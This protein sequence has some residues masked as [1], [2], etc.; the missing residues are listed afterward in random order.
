MA[1]RP[2]LSVNIDVDRVRANLSRES[3]R[4]AS[5]ADVLRL[6][7]GLGF[8]RWCDRWVA[9]RPLDMLWPDELLDMREATADAVGLVRAVE[10]PAVFLTDCRGHRAI[11]PAALRESRRGD[12]SR[13]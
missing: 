6:L 10:G 13:N 8:H 2:L 3:G 11:D 7:I 9:E 1:V 4:A 5:A 12:R